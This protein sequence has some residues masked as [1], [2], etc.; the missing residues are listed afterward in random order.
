MRVVEAAAF[1]AAPLGG[2][3]LAQMGA[4]VIRIDTIGGGLDYRRWPVTEDDTSLFWCGLN[5]C[6]RSVALDL[7]SPQGRELA[8]AL[9]CAP[10]EDAGLFLTNFPPRGWLDHDT[11]ARAPRRPDPAH[12][13]WAT[14]MADRRSTTRSMRASAC[15]CSP[16]TGHRRGRSTTCCRRGTWSPGQMVAVGLLAAERH[17]RRTGEGQHVKLA[18][19]GRGARGDGP[20]GLHRGSAARAAARAPRQRA[21]RRFRARL[22]QRRRRARDG[23]G[24]HAASS[25]ARCATLSGIQEEVDGARSPGLGSIWRRKATGSARAARTRRARRATDRVRD[26][27]RKVAPEFDRSRRVLG[28]LPGHRATGARRPGVLAARTRCSRRSSSPASARCLAAGVAAGLLGALAAAARAGA[29]A[30]A[31]HGAGAARTAGHR[32]G[33]IRPAAR[34]GHCRRGGREVIQGI[35]IDPTGLEGTG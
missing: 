14:G 33:R 16:A 18:L 12:A 17:R 5:K 13:A 24:A 26:P 30:G 3:T 2:M 1:V 7:A 31:A 28:P 27:S 4:D 22:R 8:M 11:A 10:G 29:A 6:K 20:P 34:P 32:F 15:R 25:G 23:R 35:D 21:V 9:V 19:R